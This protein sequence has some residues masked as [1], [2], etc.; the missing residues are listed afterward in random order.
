VKPSEEI[1]GQP[2]HLDD[3][4]ALLNLLRQCAE[5]KDPLAFMMLEY[6]D[7]L[8]LRFSSGFLRTIS[9]DT[10]EEDDIKGLFT[11]ICNTPFFWQE[12]KVNAYHPYRPEDNT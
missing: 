3:N 12:E 11:S 2:Q 9:S 7:S 1:F 4:A 5:Q 10:P 8:F 6:D